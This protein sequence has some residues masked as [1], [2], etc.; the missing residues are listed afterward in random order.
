VSDALADS[1]MLQVAN[2]ARLAGYLRARGVDPEPI[3]HAAGF[4]PA[5]LL[6]VGG[7]VPLRVDAL[8]FQL[9]ADRLADPA[10]GLSL[11][12]YASSANAYALIGMLF[13]RSP[14]LRSALVNLEPLYNSLVA[15][16]RVRLELLPDRARLVTRWEVDV[17]GLQLVRQEALAGIF[18]AARAMS[19]DWTPLAVCF[20]EQARDPAPFR[21]LFGVD[22]RFGAGRDELVVPD[23][24]LDRPNPA[25]D[26]LLVVHLREAAET[27]VRRRREAAGV[28]D[29]LLRLVG[30]VVDLRTGVVGRGD[31][32]ERLTPRERDLLLYL[33]RRA[34]QV[35]TH[36]EIEREVWGLQE[37][38]VTFAPAVAIRRLR[39][40]IEPDD[41][42][43]VNLVTEFGEGWRLKVPGR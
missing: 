27:H 31:V 37:A 26:P 38:V 42:N 41:K 30:A 10:L 32:V 9:A 21:E 6:E 28:Q 34:N 29:D 19:G 8:A 36:D 24:A 2:L 25:H 1:T 35:V 3:L 13:G 17:P 15:A 43:P 39:R 22:V 7:L 16:A 20:E 23:E 18:L 5:R 12:R 14:D 40:K 4:D 11:A 33:V